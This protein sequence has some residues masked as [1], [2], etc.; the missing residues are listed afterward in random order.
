MSMNKRKSNTLDRGPLDRCAL[1]K[2]N[3]QAFNLQ[4]TELL[5]ELPTNNPAYELFCQ[6]MVQA[7]NET[8]S[9]PKK[10][11]KPWFDYRRDTL[12]RLINERNYLM[13]ETQE[14]S[15]SNDEYKQRQCIIKRLDKEIEEPS[16]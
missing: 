14:L 10:I 9:R 6:L 3:Q 16:A 5:N 2:E 1:L 15:L 11:D 7:A 8:S 12:T 13:H 4:F